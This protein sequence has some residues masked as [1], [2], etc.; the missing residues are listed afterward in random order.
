AL[1]CLLLVSCSN[2]EPAPPPVEEEPV[3]FFTGKPGGIK[4]GDLAGLSG[5]GGDSMPVNAILWR[6]ALE[7][8]SL[9]PIAD[10]DTF[11][12]T[13]VSDWYSL[14][15]KP[16]ERIKIT[17]FISGRE[18]R[19]D[20]VRITVHVQNREGVGGNWGAS[21]RDDEFATRLEDLV[22]NRARE[23]RAETITE[24]VE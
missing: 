22:L 20:A 12:G 16:N 1:I 19:S 15:D 23:I 13:I 24:V 6:A 3:S 14:P 21:V 11:G 7:I 8:I 18:L 5:E 9:I 10:V 2:F 17:I 4:L